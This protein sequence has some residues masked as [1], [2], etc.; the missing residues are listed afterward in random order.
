MKPRNGSASLEATEVA[1]ENAKELLRGNTESLLLHLIAESGRIHGYHLIKE[2]NRRSKGYFRFRE[3]TVYPALHKLE[4]EGLILGE[5]G[6]RAGRQQ[7]RYYSITPKGREALSSR[8]RNWRAFAMAMDM[9]LQP[10]R[11]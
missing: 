8:L 1:G 10:D 2:I 3:G 9:V 11:A 5:W 7:R 6:A 4:T